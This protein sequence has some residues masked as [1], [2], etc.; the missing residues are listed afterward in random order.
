[1]DNIY[2]A[3]SGWEGDGSAT[4]KKSFGVTAPFVATPIF[5]IAERSGIR[6]PVRYR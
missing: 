3:S 2:A 6:L 4:L 1:M 5:S